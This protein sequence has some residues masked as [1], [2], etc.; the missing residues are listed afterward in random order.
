MKVTEDNHAELRRVAT[1]QGLSDAEV[2]TL[3]VCVRRRLLAE[4]EVLYEDGDPGDTLALVL[5]GELAVRRTGPLGTTVELRRVQPGQLVG[6]LVCVDPAPRAATVVAVTETLAVELNRS[7]LDQL[8]EHA[9]RVGSHV[10]SMILQ[11]TNARL[12]EIDD[13]IGRATGLAVAAPRTPTPTR[14]QAEPA[15]PASAGG[16]WRNLIDRLRTTT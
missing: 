15:T 5:D 12:R 11:T 7:S 10:V 9:P 1:L 14:P 16:T 8:I 2:D 4:G 13:Q 3:I 6:E